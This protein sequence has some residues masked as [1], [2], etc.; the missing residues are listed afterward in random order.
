MQQHDDL[1]VGKNR[2]RWGIRGK[3]THLAD[4]A[5]K[6]IKESRLRNVEATEIQRVWENTA[7]RAEY[8]EVMKLFYLSLLEDE[9]VRV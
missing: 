1:P 6:G 3:K 4:I 9:Q 8:R 2:D 7:L 5:S